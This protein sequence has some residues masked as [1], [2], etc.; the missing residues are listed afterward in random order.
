VTALQPYTLTPSLLQNPSSLQRKA[1]VYFIKRLK[2]PRLNCFS[3]H[4]KSE[5]GYSSHL[6]FSLGRHTTGLPAKRPRVLGGSHT[7]LRSQPHSATHL[8]KGQLNSHYSGWKATP[9][10]QPRK[11]P[12]LLLMPLNVHPPPCGRAGG[13]LG[14]MT[15]LTRGMAAT[16]P[17]YHLTP[18]TCQKDRA[19]VKS[20]FCKSVSF[21][22]V[23]RVSLLNYHSII[24][25]EIVINLCVLLN[26][27]IK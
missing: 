8:N 16:A 26:R 19:A 21:N 23:Q 22:K 10:C 2:N 24:R 27:M 17:A 25:H 5:A 12:C 13:G 4:I 15:T 14:I 9:W 1:S 18:P 11:L 7:A 20:H 6:A 3:L